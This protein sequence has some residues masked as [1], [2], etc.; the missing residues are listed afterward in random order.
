MLAALSFFFILLYTGNPVHY[1]SRGGEWAG[2]L[3][4]RPYSYMCRTSLQAQISVTQDHE[5]LSLVNSSRLCLD[6]QSM[7]LLPAIR[8][9]SARKGV[10]YVFKN[11]VQNLL[12]N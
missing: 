7:P 1:K 8:W 9:A 6:V 5:I 11:R 2:Q 10:P 12:W 4:G 3:A